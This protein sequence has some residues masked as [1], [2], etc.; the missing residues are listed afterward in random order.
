M[1]LIALAVLWLALVALV[2]TMCRL[3]SHSDNA[4]VDDGEAAR[5][6]RRPVRAQPTPRIA[7]PVRRQPRRSGLGVE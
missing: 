4:H 7:K 1:L 6:P 3:A 5:H 2:L